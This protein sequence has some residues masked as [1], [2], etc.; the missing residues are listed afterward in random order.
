M[1]IAT[2]TLLA[3]LSFGSTGCAYFTPTPQLM[4][5]NADV[6][7]ETDLPVPQGFVL[8]PGQSMTHERSSFRRMHLVYKRD[9]YLGQERVSEFVRQ[10]YPEAG[11][12]LDFVYGLETYK[13]ILTRDSEECSIEVAEDFGDAFTTMT[14]TLEPRRTPEGGYVARNPWNEG[15]SDASAGGRVDAQEPAAATEDETSK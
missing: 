12:Q 8:D 13:L 3:A 11:W 5:E 10:F 15:A 6:Q 14:I 1:R 7:V 2:L 9:A 4:A